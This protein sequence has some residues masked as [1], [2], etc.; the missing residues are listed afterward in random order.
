MTRLIQ[1]VAGVSMPTLA[2]GLLIGLLMIVTPSS[3]HHVRAQGELIQIGQLRL[4][5]N[6]SSRMGT[7]VLELEQMAPA[8]A[9]EHYELWMQSDAGELLQ[10][11]AFEVVEGVVTFEGGIEQNLL[12][13]YSRVIISL[14]PDDDPDVAAL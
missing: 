4:A 8:P 1:T 12:V 10:L 11:G 14:E 5:D 2:M 9:G 13:N 6:E 3:I 7:F